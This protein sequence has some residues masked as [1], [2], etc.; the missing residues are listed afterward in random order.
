MSLFEFVLA[1]TSIITSLALAHVIV[2][3][4]QLLRHS[5]GVRFS[6]T[7]AL[8][9]WT[10]FAIT[11]GNWAVTWEHRHMTEWPAWS[12]LLLVAILIGQYAFCAFVTPDALQGK[13]DLVAFHERE[14]PRYIGAIIAVGLIALAFNVAMGGAGNFAN[15]LRDSVVSF[16]AIAA[17]WL[18][19]VARAPPIQVSVALL[20]A[21]LATY[22]MLAAA[23]GLT[24]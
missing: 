13:V 14:G 6:L 17:A 18:A 5:D 21:S 10:A 23:S 11:I 24:T 8:W 4:A 9:L 16:I 22:F 19:L 12:V 2:G 15:W 1:L 7:H 3:V 20:E